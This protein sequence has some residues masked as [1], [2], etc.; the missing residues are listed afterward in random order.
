M[1]PTQ[2]TQRQGGVRP[3]NKLTTN[4]EKFSFKRSL[5]PPP[6][7]YFEHIAHL[8]LKGSGVWRD[9]V[10]PF[11]DDKSPSLRV[12]IEKGCFT[13]MACDAKGGDV[14]AYHMRLNGMSFI[15]AAKA[16]GAWSNQP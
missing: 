14:L 3:Y 11:H 2:S 5:L 16:L 7:H 15:A 10:C 12:N 1:N 4:G 9:A 13:C 8:H 6:A